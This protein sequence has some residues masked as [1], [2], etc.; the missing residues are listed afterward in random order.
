MARVVYAVSDPNPK[1][2]GGGAQHLRAAG[3]EVLEGVCRTQAAELNRGYFMR[4]E[5]G[6]PLVRVKIAMSLDACSALEGG[7]SQWITGREARADVHR[8]RAESCAIA[9]GHYD[10]QI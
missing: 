3:I 7:E 9:T 8:L 1:V 10:F 6:R 2:F 5:R 4:V